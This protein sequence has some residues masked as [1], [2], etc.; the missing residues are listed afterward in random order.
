MRQIRQIGLC[1]R[2]Q[3]DEKYVIIRLLKWN[4]KKEVVKNGTTI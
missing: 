3:T 1:K 2:L 4:K